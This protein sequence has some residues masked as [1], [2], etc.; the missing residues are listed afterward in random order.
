MYIGIDK[1]D[2]HNLC[3]RPRH[4]LFKDNPAVGVY[5]GW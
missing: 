1:L 5:F 3:Y 4:W 2:N